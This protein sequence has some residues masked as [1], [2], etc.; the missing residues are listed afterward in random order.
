MRHMTK[1]NMCMYAPSAI[2]PIHMRVQVFILFIPLNTCVRSCGVYTLSHHMYM[3]KH[4]YMYMYMHMHMHMYMCMH[5]HMYMYMYM[6][7][8]IR[9]YIPYP[10]QMHVQVFIL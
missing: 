5:M 3:Y 1:L 9:M 8:H 4:M 10:I 7:M 6:H 2:H